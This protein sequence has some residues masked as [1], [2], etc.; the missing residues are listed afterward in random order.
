MPVRQ[1]RRIHPLLLRNPNLNTLGLNDYDSVRLRMLALASAPTAAEVAEER[2][3]ITASKPYDRPLGSHLR[4][5]LLD[6]LD[7]KTMLGDAAD[8]PKPKNPHHKC[9]ICGEVKSKP[10]SYVCGHSHCYACIRVQLAR[11]FKCPTCFKIMYRPPF[12]QYAEEEN[13]AAEYAWWVA[14]GGGEYEWTGLV[15][16]EAPKS[17]AAGERA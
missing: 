12:R 6:P 14:P 8:E 2:R 1:T 9:G 15:F 7:H 16:P 10:V 3:R 11:D 5:C 4:R 13:L 17:V